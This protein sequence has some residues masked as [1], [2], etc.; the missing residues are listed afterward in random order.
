MKNS[1]AQ[2]F[3]MFSLLKFAFPTM[4][5]MVFMSLYTIVDGIFV[6]RY[7]GSNALSAVN[8]V[9]P[10]INLLYAC[11][12]MLAT[13]GSA[14]VA[15]LLGEKKEEEAKEN[16]T[17]L[18]LVSV[19]IGVLLFVLGTV[20]LEPVVRALG[21]TD[22]ILYECKTYLFII[23]AFGAAA[24]LQLFFQTFFVTAGKP[25]LGL[26]LTIISGLMNMALDYVFMGP[27]GMGVAGAALATGLGQAFMAV[28]GVLY[29]FIS[30]KTLYFRKPVFRKKVLLTSCGNGSSEMVSNLSLAV[31][32]YL[33]NITMMRMLGEDGVA[34]ITIVLYG[35]FLFT[36]LYLGFS[37]GVA[38]VFSYN[39]GNKNV[40]QLKRIYKIC[41]LFITISSVVIVMLALAFSEPIVHIFV[42]RESGTYKIAVE[43]F[44]LFSFNYLLA[45]INIFA[46]AM[47][48]AF[49]NGK[50]SAI[51]SFC[52]TFIFIVIS[53]LTLPLVLGTTG[54]WLSVPVAEFI[55]LFISIYY[56]RSQRNV[57]HYA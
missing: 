20:F 3:N 53:I 17:F 10:V 16:F 6:S 33:F 25:M 2:K 8:I 21:A 47:F 51:I 40:E 28:I 24:M 41:M 43:G 39:Y 4:I 19:I 1:I 48:T 9:Y 23:L 50:I 37:M 13:G 7:V 54:V 29:F 12:I 30:R 46:S 27:L 32:T 36:S 52:R 26:V 49:S 15:K 56:F 57:Y 44:F 34:A 31:I 42:G 5:M 11:G 14:I 55:T 22:I 38:P 35:Q 18:A 45:G